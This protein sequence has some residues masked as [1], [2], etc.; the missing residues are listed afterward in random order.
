M[1]KEIFINGR[2][3]YNIIVEDDTFSLFYSSDEAWTKPDSLVM[4]VIDDGN[5]FKIKQRKKDR[6]DYDEAVELSVL[7][8]LIFL[9]REEKFEMIESKIEL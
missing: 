1:K 3:D 2:H 6:L 9:I 7:F 4:K 8:R 5:G